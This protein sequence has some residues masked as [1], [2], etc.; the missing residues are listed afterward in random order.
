[1][2]RR[3]GRAVELRRARWWVARLDPLRAGTALLVVQVVLLG[4]AALLTAVLHD[5]LVEVWA[6]RN[7]A[8]REI[9]A[10]GGVAAVEESALRVPAFV[11]VAVVLFLVVAP[12]IGVL[13]AFWRHRA[14]WSRSALTALAIFGIVA[15]VIGLRADPP[16]VFSVL[17]S[18]TIALNLALVPCLWHPA[19]P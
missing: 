13:L 18:L 16:A 4:V 9:L 12:L 3:P 17:A 15:A 6:G 10:S 2:S 19:A 14:A 11:P 7:A 8:A 5:D 1:M